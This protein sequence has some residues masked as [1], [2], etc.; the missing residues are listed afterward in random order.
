MF[1]D[2]KH[3]ALL[4]RAKERSLPI[5]GL[6]ACFEVLSLAAAI[7]QDCAARLSPRNL[8]EARFIL[9]CLLEGREQAVAPH[10]LAEQMGVTRATITGLLDGLER[11]GLASRAPD[12]KDRRSVQVRLT[13]KGEATARA[14]LIEH[15]AWIDSLVV[16]LDADERRQLGALLRKIWLRT[17]A[18]RRTGLSSTTNTKEPA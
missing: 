8:S 6:T 13:P 2:I 18:G 5:E 7:D 17:D 15:A 9:I 11:D 1:P 12:P 16:D 4:S 14:A 3:S 10:A